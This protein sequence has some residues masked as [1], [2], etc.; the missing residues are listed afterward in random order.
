MRGEKLTRILSEEKMVEVRMY[1]CAVYLVRLTE[2]LWFQKV[3]ELR[4]CRGL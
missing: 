3:M 2:N 4:F 1:G